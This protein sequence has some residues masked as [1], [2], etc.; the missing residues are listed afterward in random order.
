[1]DQLKDTDVGLL[2][3]M[4]GPESVI[5]RRV[6]IV[7]CLCNNCSSGGSDHIGCIEMSNIV[8]KAFTVVGISEDFDVGIM[9]EIN[10]PLTK[11]DKEEKLAVHPSEVEFWRPPNKIKKEKEDA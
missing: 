1:M 5:G 10:K 3:K 11:Y 2:S 7:R 9:L 4:I 8:G 6:R